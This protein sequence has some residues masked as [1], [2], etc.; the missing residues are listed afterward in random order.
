MTYGAFGI[1]AEGSGTSG[2]PG[3]GR[4]R[5]ED[6]KF[7]LGEGQE[8]SFVVRMRYFGRSPR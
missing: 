1:P 4:P 7:E 6:A 3:P 5:F 2:E 8:R